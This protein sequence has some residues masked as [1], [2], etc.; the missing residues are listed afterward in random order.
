MSEAHNRKH[1]QDQNPQKNI[2]EGYQ[3]DFRLTLLMLLMVYRELS[4]TQISNLSKRSKTT[5]VR[6]TNKLIELGLI[7][8]YTKVNEKRAGNLKRKYFRIVK[9]YAQPP[10]DGIISDLFRSID[11]EDLPNTI[12]KVCNAQKALF[13]IVQSIT[14][15]SQDLYQKLVDSVSQYPSNEI[16]LRIPLQNLLNPPEELPDAFLYFLSETQFQKYT[17]LKS[18]FESRLKDI[19]DED[20]GSERPYLIVDLSIPIKKLLDI[21]Y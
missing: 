11:P 3:H 16:S 15:M 9:D 1:Q 21:G 12:L 4:L 7:E 6:H 10:E 5:I 17:N 14:K 18:E 20:I 19:M 8:S 2:L 13:F